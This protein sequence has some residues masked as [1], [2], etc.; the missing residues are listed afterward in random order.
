[1]KELKLRPTNDWY[2]NYSWYECNSMENPYQT[3]LYKKASRAKFFALLCPDHPAGQA[4]Q[5]KKNKFALQVRSW[6]QGSPAL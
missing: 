3:H 2:S 1:V 5:G 6:Q 4:G